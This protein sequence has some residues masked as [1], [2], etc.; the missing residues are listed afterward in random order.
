MGLSAGA[1]VAVAAKSP[2]L[3]WVDT[4]VGDDV[5]DAF[6]L[7]LILRSPELKVLGISTTYGDTEMRARL[8]DRLVAA[9]GEKGT[10]V[11]AG[12]RSETRN[13]LTQAPYAERSPARVHADGVKAMLAAIQAHPGELTLIAL[14]PLVTVGA[15]IERDPATFRKLKRV[16]MMG[17]SIYRG[18][19]G[20]KGQA[21]APPMPE[22]NID[23]YPKGFGQLLGAGVPL[24]LMP[25]DSTQIPLDAKDRDAL[26]AVGNPMTDQLTLLYHQWVWRTV[27]HNQTPT[28][29]D[30]VAAAYTFRPDLCPTKPMRLTVDEKGM[31]KPVEG[32]PN[33]NVCLTSDELGFLK[34]L[35]GRLEGAG[36]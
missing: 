12:P 18:Y 11:Y 30:P 21:P 35:L 29:F 22:W 5:D 31:T 28:L 33:A 20:G 6:A 36:K 25:L 14:G 7:G 17:G 16:V 13:V 34:L 1:Q 23:Q 10:P 2:Q 26:F 24:Y 8:L 3:V 15:T 32:E 9:T 27:D 4:D 19:G